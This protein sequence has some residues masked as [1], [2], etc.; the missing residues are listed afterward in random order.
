[1]SYLKLEHYLK[2]SFPATP[3]GAAEHALF[4]GYLTIQFVSLEENQSH[5]QALS[6]LVDETC[7]RLDGKVDTSALELSRVLLA[8]IESSHVELLIPSSNKSWVESSTDDVVC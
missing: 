7:N 2:S 8:S 5:V 3:H 1:M 6:C 4:L